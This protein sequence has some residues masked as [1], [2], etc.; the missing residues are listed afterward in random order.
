MVVQHLALPEGLADDVIP[1]GFPSLH[2]VSAVNED[3]FRNR[4]PGKCPA[5]LPQFVPSA[6][7]KIE[8]LLLDY[9][10]VDVGI[11]GGIAPCVRRDDGRTW[12]GGLLLDERAGVSYPD[13]QEGPDG[14]IRII[15]DY[16]RTGDQTILMAVFREEDAAAGAAVS[17]AVKLRQLVSR[18]SGG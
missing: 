4:K 2:F 8:W 18:G 11:G 6:S 9:E 7:P 5:N 16:S 12:G 3:V 10:Q 1:R 14:L 13:G 15:Y 17:G